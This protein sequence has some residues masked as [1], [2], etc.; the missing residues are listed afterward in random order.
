LAAV[1]PAAARTQGEFAAAMAAI[2]GF[3][4]RPLV[5]V[6][7]SGGP[8]S[9]ALAILAAR[10]V[11]ERDGVAW[12]LTVDHRLRPESSIEAAKV[13]A[14]LDARGIPHA[15]LVWDGDKPATGIQQAAREARYRLLAGWC[16][17]QGCLHL[18][19]AHQRDDQAET[20][21][22]RRRA[23]SGPAGL[24]G[25][26]V[27]REL[28]QLRIVRPLLGV[29]RARLAALLGDERQDYLRDPSNINPVF[30]RSRVR[31]E[32]SLE[33]RENALAD[34]K[35]HAAARLK[36]ERTLAT[37]LGRAV[38]LHPAGLALLDPAPLSAAG[39]EMVEQALGRVAAVIG[40]ATYPLRR[41]RLVR[42]REAL[43]A[44]PP[45]AHTLGGCRFVPWRDQVLVLRE[46]ARAAASEPIE[47][48]T[49]IVWDRRFVAGLPPTA[50][51]RLS[52]G[53]LGQQ[54]VAAL[55]PAATDDETPLPRLVYPA[56]PAFREC[57]SVVAVPHVDYSRLPGL[58]PY[59]KF[60]PAAPL[61]GAGFTV[62]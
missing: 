46:I 23:K 5:A 61:F 10:W 2:G 56:L 57:G 51:H 59:L 40:G 32:T 52:L 41:E 20:H 54:G 14:W 21:L 16:A 37:L 48:G 9:M 11:R 35:V 30:E 47:P 22:I 45:R 26:S 6:A 13:G 3:E 55:P 42:L 36:G 25:M 53:S 58:Q 18:L 12:A 15:V 50:P 38:T 39:N 1:E 33:A 19:L 24:A 7:V 27:V 60:H 28:A 62:V 4:P 44:A 8:D 29:R 43:Q 17:A 34:L 31:M 49:M